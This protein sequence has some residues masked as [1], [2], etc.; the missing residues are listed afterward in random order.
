MT[1]QQNLPEV[2][3]K[4]KDSSSNWKDQ[5]SEITVKVLMT[6]GISAGGFGAFWSLFKESDIPKAIASGVIGLGITYGASLLSPL[7]QGNQRRLGQAGN[8]LDKSIDELVDQ[9]QAKATRAEEAYLLAQALDCRDY[10][11]E[12]MGK[13]DRIAIPLLQEVYVALELDSSAVKAGLATQQQNQSVQQEQCIWDFLQLAKEEPAYRKLAIIASGGSGKTTLLKHL[14]YTYGSRQHKLFGV[15]MLIPV[16]LLLRS[17]R[18]ILTQDKPPNLPELVMQNHLKE[19]AKLSPK[20]EKLPAG[21]FEKVLRRGDAL[22]LLDGFDEIPE[23]ER[24]IFERWINAQ[25]RMFDKSVFLITSRPTA[26]RENYVDSPFTKIWVNPL[27]PKQQEAF[28]KQWYLCQEKLDRDGRDTPEVQ[29]DAGQNAEN[30]LNQIRD[31]NRPELSDLAQN[32]LLLNL[33]ARAHRSDPSMQL[34]RQRAELYQD[35]V[36]LQLKKRPNARDIQLLLSPDDRQIVLQILALKMMNRTIKLIP[37]DQLH[38]LVQ[39]ILDFRKYQVSA[40]DFLKQI[41]DVS[42]LIVRQGLE[43]CEFSHLS[44]QEFLAAAEIKALKQESKLYPYLKDANIPNKD[45]AWWR[46]TILLYTSQVNPIALIQEAL[47]QDAP[48]IAFDCWQETQYTIDPIIEAQLKAL[49]PTLRSRRYS[50]LELLLKAGKWREADQETYRLMIT[51]VG[52][53]EGQGFSRQDLEEFP[54][55]DL[56][57]IDNLWVTASNGHFGFSV[58]KKIWEKCGSPMDYN[59]DYRKFG[60]TVGWRFG[61]DFVNYE[62]SYDQYN[63]SSTLSPVGELPSRIARD[64]RVTGRIG[65][66]FSRAA[67]CKL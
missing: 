45:K 64:H 12:G 63:F 18:K 21:W 44:F 51:I 19:L 55:E 47:K 22:I 25:I 24:P 39:K 67:T 37:E 6:G 52:K 42:E 28:V 7:H 33:L 27:T 41:I 14:A 4:E 8:K 1:E 61:Y 15:P 26:Y 13:R 66:L 50:K 29:R 35:I 58:Q 2:Q 32:P 59:G 36:T 57:T 11:T 60:K 17:Y 5:L 54:C 56:L 43:G 48:D 65:Y 38:N 10:K 34:P 31:R 3:A 30:L 9:L 53:E 62:L 20:L 40:N 16:L 23:D 49:E 46:G